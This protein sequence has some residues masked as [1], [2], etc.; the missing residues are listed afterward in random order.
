MNTLGTMNF[1][2]RV[3]MLA[4]GLGTKAKAKLKLRGVKV[5]QQ[6]KSEASLHDSW[7]LFVRLPSGGTSTHSVLPLADSKCEVE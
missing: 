4:R 2:D 7:G 1:N 6:I 5:Y 3:R